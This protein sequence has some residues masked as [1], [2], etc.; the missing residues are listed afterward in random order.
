MLA[1]SAVSPKIHVAVFLILNA[2][3]VEE[4]ERCFAK[5]LTDAGASSVETR[6]GKA[7]STFAHEPAPSRGDVIVSRF[8]CNCTAH[9]H[10][11]GND[12]LHRMY[13]TLMECTLHAPNLLRLVYSALLPHGHIYSIAELAEI[14]HSS[15]LPLD[16][17]KEALRWDPFATGEHSSCDLS[18]LVTVVVTT[19]PM[20]SGSICTASVRVL[21]AHLRI[22]AL[23]V[24][25]HRD[26]SALTP[27]GCPRKQVACIKDALTSFLLS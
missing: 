15:L 4:A 1:E 11:C 14:D 18:A 8:S 19:S 7:P 22:R 25:P 2:G 16:C 9:T 21:S 10:R 27:I 13:S 17:P 5:A 26:P 24:L 12:I 3:S 23:V 6:S 20:R